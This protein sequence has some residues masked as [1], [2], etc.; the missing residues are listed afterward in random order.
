MPNMLVDEEDFIWSTPPSEL[1]LRDQVT[2]G[3][4]ESSAEVQS[5]S[6]AE[7]QSESSAEAKPRG[8]AELSS[9]SERV[10]SPQDKS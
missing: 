6:S 7:V 3:T 10:E 9:F 2:A 5:E 1:E 8:N 4:E